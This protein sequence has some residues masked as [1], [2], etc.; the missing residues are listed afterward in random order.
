MAETLKK[1][2][3]PKSNL[4]SRQKKDYHTSIKKD[5][6]SI[7][8]FDKGQGFGTLKTHGPNSLVEKTESA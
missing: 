2:K 8:P 1:A 7:L 3:P 4:T 6:L 5:N